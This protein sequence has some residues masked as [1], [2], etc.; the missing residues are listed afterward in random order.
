MFEIVAESDT[1]VPLFK[2]KNDRKECFAA[3]SFCQV[4]SSRLLKFELKLKPLTLVHEMFHKVSSTLQ[5]FCQ[6][7][8]FVFK[9]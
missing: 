6:C 4:F 5:I 3:E 9:E 1:R 7:K 8:V 2:C